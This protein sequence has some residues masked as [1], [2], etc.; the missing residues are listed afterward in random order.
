MDF[1]VLV[2]EIVKRV[3][4]KLET[5]DG[6]P[7]GASQDA[8]AKPRLL[9]L[10]QEHD[11]ICHEMLEHPR[12]TTL[13][14]LDC[15]K[16][17]E[18]ACEVQDYEAVIAFDLTVDAMARLA[19]GVCDTPFT[20]LAQRAILLG[21][22]IFVPEEAVELLAMHK[23]VPSAYYQML[24]EKLTLLKASGMVVCPGA[25]LVDAIL[26]GETAAACTPACAPCTPAAAPGRA[27]AV[28]K[29]VITERDIAAVY[30]RDVGAV[31]V[32][33]KSI[34]TDLAREYA[35]A[36]GVLIVRD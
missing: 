16:L 23:T 26:S 17:A 4:E 33:R 18:Y 22:K 9:V 7:G 27:V 10:T 24:L 2:D 35:A 11:T 6:V 1:S 3:A 25:A 12:L 28:C 19:G 21:K 20:A 8:G 29:K 36:R 30:G 13:Y 32:G 34:V 15:A 31:H 14:R 5:A